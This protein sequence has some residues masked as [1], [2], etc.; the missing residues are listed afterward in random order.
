MEL[1]KNLINDRKLNNFK[2]V[3]GKITLLLFLTFSFNSCTISYKF[4]GS[5]IDYTK[6][7]T[8]SIADF[9]NNAELI[10]PPLSQYFSE[11]LKDAYTKQTRLQL[12]KKGGDL[13]I[14]GEIVGYQLTPMAISA[15][16][17]ASETKL[18]LTINVRFS[19]SKNP[20]EDFEKKYSA[21]QTFNSSRM[22]TD[23]QDELMQTMVSE[24]TD[25]I[26]NDTVAKW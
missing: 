13:N 2:L 21:F 4:N 8:L 17:Y 10:Y 25:N 7:K 1:N 15:D 23:V 24:I 20:E 9:P 5:S 14:E 12:I 16:S 6:T 22:L 19:N 26:Y 11:A 3:S 18:T